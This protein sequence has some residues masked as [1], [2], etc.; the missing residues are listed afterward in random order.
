MV[1][2]L[3]FLLLQVKLA[4]QESE[5]VTLLKKIPLGQ[6]E[7]NIL[8][9]KA[10]QLKEGKLRSRGEALLPLT[11]ASFIFDLFCLPGKLLSIVVLLSIFIFISFTSTS[12]HYILVFIYLTFPSFFNFFLSCLLAFLFYLKKKI[13]SCT[14]F[15][16]FIVL[17]FLFFF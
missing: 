4:Y 6:T 12:P 2:N 13:H 5:L 8:R 7:L 16:F 1:Y 17:E 9:E 11:L 14:L 15:S 3:E 10:E